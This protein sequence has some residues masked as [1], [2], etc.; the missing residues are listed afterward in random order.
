[1]DY[2]WCDYGKYGGDRLQSVHHLCLGSHSKGGKVKFGEFYWHGR[3]NYSEEHKLMLIEF[4]G[5]WTND[6]PPRRHALALHDDDC[7][8]LLPIGHAIYEDKYW[9]AGTVTHFNKGKIVMQ[10]ARLPSKE[11]AA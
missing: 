9:T 5:S 7:F 2:V 10:R 11:T 1:M 8:E 3:W 4:I 6:Q